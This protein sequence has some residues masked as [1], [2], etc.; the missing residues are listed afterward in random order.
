MALP[1]LLIPRSGSLSVNTDKKRG[2]IASSLRRDSAIV[3]DA[4]ITPPMSPDQGD[5]DM[6]AQDDSMVTEP[7]VETSADMEIDSNTPT[8]SVGSTQPSGPLRLLE[9]EQ[10]HIQRSGLKLKD[11][12][13][14][15]TLGALL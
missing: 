7:A 8:D 4:P 3:T 1:S 13:V 15:G 10:V 11:F 9:D 12:E 6:D 2:S 5:K 14:R